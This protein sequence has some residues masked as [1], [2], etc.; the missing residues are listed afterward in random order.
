MIQ[1]EWK[2]NMPFKLCVLIVCLIFPCTA[3]AVFTILPDLVNVMIHTMWCG[4]Y[5]CILAWL[6]WKSK[7]AKCLVT[8]LNAAPFLLLCL[9]FLMG[10]PAGPAYL[11]L[12][13]CLPFVPW[14]ILLN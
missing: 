7:T 6:F 4:L 14:G 11:L 13:A 10:G 2:E 8:L 1:T 9:G 12:K 5:G 3:G